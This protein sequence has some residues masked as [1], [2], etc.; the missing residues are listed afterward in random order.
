M[1]GIL[2]SVGK[3]CD[4]G[5]TV[6]FTAR[7]AYVQNDR[8]GEKT[9]MARS[10]GLYKLSLWVKAKMKRDEVKID[11]TDVGFVGLDDNHI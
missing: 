6:V 7:G 4:A 8:T 1:K 9:N 10:R 2:A 3:M 11:N 5:N